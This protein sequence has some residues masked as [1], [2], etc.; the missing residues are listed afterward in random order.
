MILFARNIESPQQVRALTDHMRQVRPDILIAV[1]Q[2]GGRVQRLDRVL[3][4]LS[5]MGRLGE[6]YQHSPQTVRIE[7][8]EQCGWLMATEVLAVGIDFSFATCF[9]FKMI[10]VM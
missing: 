8:A 1:D 7:L 5:A 2:E 3:L 10:L 9:G 4:L 6:H